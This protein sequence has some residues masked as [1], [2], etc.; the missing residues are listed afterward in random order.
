MSEIV[1]NITASTQ[2]MVTQ[3]NV[4]DPKKTLDN[5]GQQAAQPGRLSTTS[6][7]VGKMVAGNIANYCTSNVGKYTG[8]Q[9]NQSQI[10][11]AQTAVGLAVT[12]YANPI[13]AGIQVATRIGTTMVDYSWEQKWNTRET[14]Q[15]MY[16]MGFTN[17]GEM[18]GYKH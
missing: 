9:H 14:R 13:I 4:L 10:N 3:Q 7:L 15:K 16:R 17:S 6:I 2:G 5:V 18:V 8:N 11:N 1:F 12:A